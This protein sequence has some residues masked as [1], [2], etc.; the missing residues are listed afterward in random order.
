MIEITVAKCVWI[1]QQLLRAESIGVTTNTES[2]GKS[3]ENRGRSTENRGKPCTIAEA[4]H[5]ES[6]SAL[7]FKCHVF[8]SF[9]RPLKDF[10]VGGQLFGTER[11]YISS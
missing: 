9:R 2:R 10:F 1:T 3:T 11:A 4:A 5:R 7:F 6:S 8:Q